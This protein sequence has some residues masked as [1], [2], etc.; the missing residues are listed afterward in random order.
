VF[1]QLQDVPLGD[2][3]Y[4]DVYVLV[5]RL[6][7][8]GYVTKLFKN[9]Q[10]YSQGEI[11]EI[12]T[13]LDKEAQLKLSEV[14]EQRL[15]R[16]YALSQKDYLF[17]TQGE[18]HEF[19]FDFGV[20]EST[21]SRNQDE[22]KLALERSEGTAH[23]ILFRPTAIGQIGDDFAFYS[24]LKVYYLSATQFPDIPKTEVRMSQ[25]AKET[26]TASLSN[27]Y[28]KVKLPWFSILFGHD[29]LHW[30]P[31]RR[32]ALLVSEHPLPMNMLKL[33]AQYYPVNFQAVTARLGS[34][35]DKKYLSGHRLELN[36]WDKLRLGI[37]ET[38]VYG[39]RFETVYLNPVQI[40]TTTEFVF[41]EAVGENDNV[42]I[43]GD[44]DFV[45]LKNLE[46]YGE[47]MIDDYRPFSYSPKNWGN[48]FGVLLGGYWVDP[49]WIPDTDLRLEYAFVN[50]YAY[51]HATKIN[52]YTHFNSVIGHQIGT[53]ADDLWL[54]LKHWFTSY[55]A[56]SLTY[57][58]Q[59]H[60]EGDINKLHEEEEGASDDDDWEFLS[61][62]TESTHSIIL[63]ASYNMIGKYSVGLEYTRSWV[64]NDDNQAGVDKTKDQVILSGQYRF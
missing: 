49:F 57:E 30:G 37:A 25:P 55:F 58:R 44:F 14:E 51:T 6:V 28:I 13:E 39:R 4:C 35:I 11:A 64:K 1:A 27:Y 53:D 36:L 19:G 47:V 7:A 38:V 33:Q 17:Q 52:A 48:K 5:D 10:P 42:L 15:N 18:K 26:Q 24:D 32:G 41:P 20:G 9:T 50:Q 62:V 56:A 22:S 21:I 2:E 16:L 40:Y 46:L 23:A 63:S 54:N 8:K 12:M 3:L 61:G 59:R 31:G 43:S 29:N 34:T 45:P 60:G